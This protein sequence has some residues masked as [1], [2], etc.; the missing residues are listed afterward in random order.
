MP[1][2]VVQQEVEAVKA[3]HHNPHLEVVTHVRAQQVVHQAAKI[4]LVV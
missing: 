1:R 2:Q 4:V 3:A